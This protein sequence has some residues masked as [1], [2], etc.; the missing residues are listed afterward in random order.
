MSEK[1]EVQGLFAGMPPDSHFGDLLVR[2][3]ALISA[4]LVKTG[5]DWRRLKSDP[6]VAREVIEIFA[7]ENCE[8]RECD[9]TGVLVKY[10]LTQANEDAT[11]V[12]SRCG[13]VDAQDRIDWAAKNNPEIIEIAWFFAF[14]FLENR[15]RFEGT[16]LQSVKVC[17][18]MGVRM[19]MGLGVNGD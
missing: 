15:E 6:G 8:C 18:E 14:L 3:L 2:N 9:G 5:Y 17:T 1:A 7:R 16:I 4:D 12:T 19:V 10:D 13:C 11:E